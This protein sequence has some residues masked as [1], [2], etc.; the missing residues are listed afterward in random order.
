MGIHCKSANTNFEHQVQLVDAFMD[1]EV[2]DQD[3]SQ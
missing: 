1:I 3:L 2:T